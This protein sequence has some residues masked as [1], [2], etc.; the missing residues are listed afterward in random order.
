MHDDVF[1]LISNFPGADT[2]RKAVRLLV[3]E[4][5]IAC[6]NLIPGVESIYEWK[7]VI[8]TAHEVT[9][10]AKTT[11][12]RADEAMTRLRALHPYDVPEILLV[13]VTTGW[14]AYLEWVAGQCESR[15]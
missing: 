13:P 12:S 8:E 4:R 5:L 7:G 10:I 6:G 1:L 3:E 2:A 15:H 9:V 14:P 11:A